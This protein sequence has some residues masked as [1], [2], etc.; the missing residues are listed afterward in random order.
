MSDVH[1]LVAIDHD[2]KPAPLNSLVTQWAKNEACRVTIVG[3]APTLSSAITNPKVI[4]LA[5]DAEGMMLNDL[6]Q[7]IEEVRANIAAPSEVHLL[8]GRAA[9]E[10][11]KAAVLH[12]AD[13]VVKTADRA[14]GERSPIFGAV[15]KKLIRKCPAPVWIVRSETDH[16]PTRIAV[17]VDNTDAAS[18][19]AEAELLAASLLTHAVEL[20]RRFDNSEITV[21]HAWSAIGLDFLENPR[22]MMAPDDVKEYVREWE[23]VSEKWLQNFVSDANT[24]YAD[25]GVTFTPKLVMGDALHAIPTATAEIGADLLVMGSANRSGIPGLFIGNTAEGIIDRVK[26]SIFVVKPEGFSSVLS[27]NI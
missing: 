20:A 7:R 17:A 18:N 21:V 27:P 19:R 9:D 13:V 8:S 6:R 12:K 1:F 14:A 25:Q 11:I 26:C 3:V 22:A 23:E 10:I 15:E 5:K 24:R 2:D 16:A 4:S